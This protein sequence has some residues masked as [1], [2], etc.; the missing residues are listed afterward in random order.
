MAEPI[1]ST[2]E[3]VKVF[4]G[5][6]ALDG[7]SLD[8]APGGIHAIIGPNGAGKTTFFNVLSGFTRA[9]RGSVRFAGQ[10][11]ARLDPAAIAR[12]GMVRS[13][14]INSVFPHLSVLDNVK[15]A[16][17][18]RTALSRRLVASPKT[19]AVLDEP[20]RE[21]LAAVGLD[22]EERVLATHLPYG[23]KRSLELAI[24]LS[25]DPQ[26]LLLDEPTAGMGAEDVDRTVALIGR[27]AAGRTIVLVEHNLRVVADLAE[28]VTVLQRGRVLVSGSYDEVR[29]DAR[30][31]TA[32][33][34]G[35]TH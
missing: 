28:R 34:G 25:Q 1:L 22:A 13:F 4:A 27:I 33:L 32:Y 10:E 15:I 2:R 3:V 19:T 20:A 7:V 23:K 14:Q 12:M 24:A 5:F 9:T 35:G 30:V 26:V 11:I 17:Q 6:T 18:A 29:A 21:A 31:V 16:L 8:V